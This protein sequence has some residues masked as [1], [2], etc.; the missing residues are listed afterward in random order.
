MQTS[1]INT[2]KLFM[3]YKGKLAEKLKIQGGFTTSK[4]F[5]ISELFLPGCVRNM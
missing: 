4:E 1:D 3:S 2:K 5:G